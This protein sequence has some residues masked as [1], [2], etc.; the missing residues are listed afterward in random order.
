M[1]K[2]SSSSRALLAPFFIF[3]FLLSAYGQSS[4]LKNINGEITTANISL[5]NV[6]IIIKG[7]NKGTK[8][9]VNG[10]YNI[11]ANIGDIIQYSHVGYTTVSIII[12]DITRTLNLEMSNNINE[13]KE[14]IV[15][16]IKSNNSASGVDYDTNKKIKTAAGYISPFL[17]P[18]KV[19]Y[20]PKEELNL[21]HHSSLYDALRWKMPKD[22]IP[23]IYD[24]DGVISKGSPYVDLAR[25]L[26]V[27]VITGSAGTIYWGGPVI[28]I[29][30]MDNPDEIKRRLEE[31]TEQHRNQNYYNDDATDLASETVISSSKLSKK[32][33][34]GIIT[35]LDE[36]LENATIKIKNSSSGTKTNSK[37]YYEV[38]AKIGAVIQYSYVGYQT[39]SIIVE[40]ITS[41]INIDMV[42]FTNKLDEV[43]VTAKSKEGKILE[44]I[45]KAEKPVV[46]ARGILDPKRATYPISFIDGEDVNPIYPTLTEALVGKMAGVSSANDPG[47]G[48]P[49]IM[50]KP[51]ASIN[52][53]IFAIWDVDGQ[54]F[55]LE[56]PIDLNNIESIHILKTLSATTKYGS[57]GAGGVVIVRTKYGTFDTAK[58]ERDKITEQFTNKNYYF[59]D[60]IT[61]DES[62]L[63]L[64]PFT[65]VLKAH[66]SVQKA[67]TYYKEK[68]KS[69]TIDYDTHIAIAHT[70]INFYSN[71][72]LGIH[73]LNDLSLKHRFN[74]EILKAIAYQFQAI[75]AYK[76]A[77]NTYKSIF[78][79]RPKYAQSYRD[80]ANAFKENDQFKEAWRTYMNYLMQGHTISDEG[81]GQLLYTEMEYLYFNRASQTKIKELFIPKNKTKVAFR[82]D[83]R[84]VVEW[85]T[86]EAEFELEFVNP[87]K[88]S[89]VFEHSLVAN[90]ELITDEKLKGYSS[91][92]FMVSDIGDGE[93]LFNIKYLGN[94]TSQPTY[95]KVTTYY[96]WGKPNQK[97]EVSV[98]KFKG[99]REKFQLKKINK[100]SLTS[101]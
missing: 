7:T 89:Y 92:E 30:T 83:V 32:F 47:T 62:A 51:T 23:S 97:K 54:I 98:Y 94:K 28:F 90:Q 36:P 55:E 77:V 26:E 11:K 43:T 50:V 37:G 71:Y 82:N 95:I 2:K 58:A 76:D 9:D 65:E 56:P 42:P 5:P 59:E 19:H 31:K 101:L 18:S 12:E 25:I 39:T 21:K 75:G 72:T 29:K 33:I 70:F 60:A 85:N 6:N 10:H 73:I 57:G 88:R 67:H 3:C 93:W 63:S 27:Y 74:P 22:K 48:R 44:R 84:L 41:E 81:I 100:Q 86:S 64:N 99:E 78:K 69:G 13:L 46:T 34:Y 14:V 24:V 15:T 91:K 53:P 45:E 87:G 79:L 38:K 20:F 35:Y 66:N 52:S 8:T 16:K 17:F 40:D 49:R 61:L 96:H 68:L 1:K 4:S 80:L